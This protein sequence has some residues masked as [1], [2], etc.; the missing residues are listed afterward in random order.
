MMNNTNINKFVQLSVTTSNQCVCFQVCV[1]LYL[2]IEL[3]NNLLKA[4]C[5]LIATFVCLLFYFYCISGQKL[6]DE[7]DE[8]RRCLGECSWVD[9]PQWFKKMLLI[10]M[11][12]SFAPFHIK[13]FG[14]YILNL[15]NFINVLKVSYS[16]LNL[17]RTL[18]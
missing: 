8:L 5:L 17:M 16:Y 4:G 11:I 3:N 6:T 7:Y 1:F 18:K 13:P 15:E 12:R 10:M 2:S 9:K 14:L